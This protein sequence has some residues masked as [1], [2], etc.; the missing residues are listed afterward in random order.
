TEGH[1]MGEAVLIDI[2]CGAIEIGV[3]HLTVYAFSTENWKRSAEEV[4][5]LMGF[6]REVVRRRRENLND[7]GVRMRWVGSR[8]RMWSSVIKEFDIAE[9]MTVDNDVIT[10]NYCVNYGGRTEIVEAARQLAQQAVDGKISPSRI[11][12][13]A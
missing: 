9:Q 8:P 11:T 12:E 10:I 7:M 5:F 2:T 6:N 13:A 4:R 3:K 1:K